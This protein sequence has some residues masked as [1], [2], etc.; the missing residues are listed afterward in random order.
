M[1]NILIV[2]PSL[3]KGGAESQ[4]MILID[5]LIYLGY[6]VTV[7]VRKNN[8]DNIYLD[9]VNLIELENKGFISLKSLYKLYCFIENEKPLFVYSWLRQMNVMVGFLNVFFCFNWVS[10][11]RSNP[12]QKNTFY[13]KLERL[14]EKRS[15]VVCNSN[16]ARSFYEQNNYNTYY[17]ANFLKYK[18]QAKVSYN[19][20]FIVVNRLIR[21]KRVTDI[22][23][24]WSLANIKSNLIIVGYG[25]ELDNLLAFSDKLNLSNVSFLGKVDDPSDLLSS[26][27]FFI[28]SSELEGMPN[29]PLEALCHNNI[30]ILSDIDV[31]KEI[32]M[33]ND[34]YLFK[35]GSVEGLARTLISAIELSEGDY[36]ESLNNQIVYLKNHDNDSN[37]E[38]FLKFLSV[39]FAKANLS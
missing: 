39:Y 9:N 17:L 25:P 19:K 31:H 16:L 38:L 36:L 11:E 3:K 32:L 23:K 22:L 34:N 33:S 15:V 18:R 28:S 13:D 20:N 2:I 1:K 24:A 30:L 12:K 8:L 27:S 7:A 29:A 4:L 14:L 5:K 35:L 10:S 37:T 6:N 26:S 21:T